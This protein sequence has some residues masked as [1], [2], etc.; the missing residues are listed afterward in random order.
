MA[1]FAGALFGATSHVNMVSDALVLPERSVADALSVNVVGDPS[2][3]TGGATNVYEYGAVL[4]RTRN[5]PLASNQSTNATSLE[6]LVVFS[7]CTVADVVYAIPL[8][9]GNPLGTGD[10]IDGTGFFVSNE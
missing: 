1:R 4:T 9:S 3:F 10:S 5:V 8:M 7:S 2:L 6:V